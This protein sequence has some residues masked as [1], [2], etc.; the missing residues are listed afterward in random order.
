MPVNQPS[1]GVYSLFIFVQL[2]FYDFSLRTNSRNNV[3]SS[4]TW[5]PYWSGIIPDEVLSNETNAFKAFSAV[6]MVLNRYNGSFP[7]TFLETGLQWLVIISL[8]HDHDV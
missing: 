5:Y 2:S 4:A 6:N 7:T 8:Q 1:S 3:F